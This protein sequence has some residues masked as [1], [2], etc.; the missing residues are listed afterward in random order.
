MCTSGRWVVTYV[1]FTEFLTEEK[2]KRYGPL[3]NVSA[4]FPILMAAFSFQ[5]I[6]KNS[7]Y[8]EM[9]ALCQTGLSGLA[10]VIAIPETPKYFIN[11]KMQE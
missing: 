7:F 5:F 10:F 3:V 2:I 1:Y 8:F 11:W 9:F 6:T 4:A